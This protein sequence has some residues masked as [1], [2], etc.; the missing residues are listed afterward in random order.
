MRFASLGS[1][2]RGNATVVQHGQTTVLLDC[3]FS[4]REAKRRL[5]RLG[6]NPEKLTAIVV[7]HEHSD[8]ISGVNTLA[9]QLDVPVYATEG[10]RRTALAGLSSVRCIS[11]H[12]PLTLADLYFE[13]FPVPH[14]AKEPCQFVITDGAMRLGVLTDTGEITAHICEQLDGCE[15]LVLECN[16]DETLLMDG[17]YPPALKHRVSGRYGH[18]SNDQAAAMLLQID[19]SR[20]K[21]LA[22]AHLSEKNNTPQLAVRALS[23]SLGCEE[24]WIQVAGQE[25]GLDWRDL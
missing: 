21:H 20:L 13:P 22:A 10:T 18:L 23:G 17:D 24:Q 2:S 6:V 3:G 14:D 19:T 8:H 5:T 15:A 1:G 16:H 4:A 7:T 11:A 25:Y 9:R 12:K